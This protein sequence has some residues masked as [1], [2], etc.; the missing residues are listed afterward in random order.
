MIL[1]FVVLFSLDSINI[2]LHTVGLHL[3][4]TT[5]EGSNRTVQHLY[6]TNLS[7]SELLKNIAMLLQMSSSLATVNELF[8]YTARIA[9]MLAYSLYCYAMFFITGDR[10]LTA[11]V[12][13]KYTLLWNEG[14][15]KISIIMTWFLFTAVTVIISVLLYIG[16]GFRESVDCLLYTSPR[17]RDS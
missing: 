6:I 9:T 14:K 3:L 15:T 17:P 2:F 16:K 1:Y 5:N 7:A 12:G 13:E 4:L 11:T 8:I 10:L